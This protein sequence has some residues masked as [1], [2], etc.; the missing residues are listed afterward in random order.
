MKQIKL[1]FLLI[2]MGLSGC[3]LVPERPPLA[4]D[5]AEIERGI[6]DGQTTVFDLRSTYGEETITNNPSQGRATHIWYHT[7]SRDTTMISVLEENDVV[8]KHAVHRFKASDYRFVTKLTESD[9]A[10]AIIPGQTTRQQIEQKY[11]KPNGN[12]YD[13]DGNLIM[14]YI[15]IDISHSKYGWIPN[16][17]GMVQ[18]LAGSVTMN[19]TDLHIQLDKQEVVKSFRVE[20]PKFWKGTGAFNM[21]G[22][23]QV[24]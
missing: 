13:D 23:K 22:L 15:D 16:V 1:L 14:E 21:S 9:L 5:I 2:T 17:G 19:V 10:A 24:K 18:N 4:G 8:I 6:V 12:S 7:F 11:G 3:A 20:K